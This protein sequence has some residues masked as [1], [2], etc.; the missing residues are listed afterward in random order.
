MIDT[1]KRT[2]LKYRQ[3]APIPTSY[4]ETYFPI[5]SQKAPPKVTLL[6]L[7]SQDLQEAAGVE[8]SS[9]LMSGIR[10]WG[11]G[12]MLLYILTAC[13]RRPLLS[14]KQAALLHKAC[15]QRAVSQ[16]C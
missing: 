1:V 14:R 12:D 15:A 4:L 7:Q 5:P 8:L 6:S 3:P 2:S 11:F 16:T 13:Y 9:L 10:E